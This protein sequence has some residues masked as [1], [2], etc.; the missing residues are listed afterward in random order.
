MIIERNLRIDLDDKYRCF[1][2]KYTA[3]LMGDGH[4]LG[5]HETDDLTEAVEFIRNFDGFY[6]VAKIEHTIIASDEDGNEF[7]V[8]SFDVDCEY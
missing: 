8:E 3:F 4:Y 6:E 7:I 2:Y 5:I 1:E